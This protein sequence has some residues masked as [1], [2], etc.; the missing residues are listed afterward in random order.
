[1]D[2]LYRFSE[3]ICRKPSRIS[4]ETKTKEEIEALII[5]THGKLNTAYVPSKI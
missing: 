4:K 2:I 1:L 3:G 5:L